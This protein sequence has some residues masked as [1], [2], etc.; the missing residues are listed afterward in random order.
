MSK[1]EEDKMET[2]E[3]S[4]SSKTDKKYTTET[5]KAIE[6]GRELIQKDKTNLKSVVSSLLSL[7][8]KT[9][10]GADNDSTS[11]IVVEIV[12]LC[13]VCGEWNFLN[14]NILLLSKKRAQSKMAIS[15]MIQKAM[16]YIENTPNR[17]SKFNLLDTLNKVT[18]GKIY[19]EIER[20][21]LAKLQARHM[22][23]DGKTLE[24]TEVLQ[25]VQI[26]TIGSMEASEKIEFILYH[27]KLTLDLKDFVRAIIISRK[28]TERSLAL[29][30]HQSLKIEYHNLM[31][32]YFKEKK[33]FIDI[34]KSHLHIYDTELILNDPKLWTEELKNVVLFLILSPH[35]NL[36]TDLMNRVYGDKKLSDLKLFKELLKI[37]ISLELINP[38]QFDSFFKSHLLEHQVF[39]D[40]VSRYQELHNRIV[41]NN[42]RV[43]SNYYT[44]IHTQR[45]SSLLLLNDGKTEEFVSKMVQNKIIQAKIDRIDGIIRFIKSKEPNDV[46]NSWS[47]DTSTL[48]SLVEKS[49]HLINKEM[50]SK[51]V[52][53]TEDKMDQIE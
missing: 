50:V 3:I 26:E 6:D 21:R 16:E 11:Q 12:T 44:R 43:I 2:E 34:A 1:K 53:T 14:E 33:S 30:E 20:A 15:K 13:A 10:L 29:P 42:I 45:L 35:D 46:L 7:E 37:F 17:E 40:D 51:K 5:K 36:R 25:D 41:E 27:F 19:V 31:I 22:V 47:S 28:I 8:K 9:R 4:E 52:V 39:K 24:A 18:E 23:E 38:Q 32:R 48:L 49:V